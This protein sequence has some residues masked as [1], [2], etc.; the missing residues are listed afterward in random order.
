MKKIGRVCVYLMVNPIGQKYVGA[1]CDYERRLAQYRAKTGVKYQKLIKESIDKYGFVNHSFSVIEDCGI[2][3][4][5]EREVFW[6]KEYGTY[7]HLG[8]N[9][10]NMTLGGMGT[11]G[12]IMSDGQKKLISELNGKSVYQYD[13][14]GNFLKKFK[15][16]TSAAIETGAD[17]TSI[18]L[19]INNHV[20]NSRS[21]GGFQWSNIYV[22]RMSHLRYKDNRNQKI[23]QVLLDGNLVKTFKNIASAS[24]ETKIDDTNICRCVNGERKTAGGFMWK[25]HYSL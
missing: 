23:D 11:R 25:I 5:H 8:F 4:L 7:C 16:I 9:G 24:D 1:T 2:D 3:S 10:L 21:S 13:I 18:S 6:I 12:H 20:R 14:Y 15:S 17:V 22:E 19:S